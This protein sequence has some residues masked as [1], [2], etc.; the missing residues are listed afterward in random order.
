MIRRR[1]DD[2]SLVLNFALDFAM[3]EMRILETQLK[4]GVASVHEYPEVDTKTHVKQTRVEFLCH[5]NEYG[6]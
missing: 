2:E 4:A 6:I 1:D 3:P 5:H